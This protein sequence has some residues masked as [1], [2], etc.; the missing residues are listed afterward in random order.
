MG[1]AEDLVQFPDVPRHRVDGCRAALYQL[2]NGADYGSQ[3]RE[4]AQG[5]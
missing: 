3:V 4:A 5:P 2:A 1:D